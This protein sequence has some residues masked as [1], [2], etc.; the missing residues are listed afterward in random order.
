MKKLSRLFH[1]K[2]FNLPDWISFSRILLSPV[3]LALCFSNE[4]T[5]AAWLLL[6]GFTSDAV[7]GY[8]ARRKEMTSERGANLDS[9]GDALLF[10]VAVVGFV[11]FE[12]EFFM[13]HIL[14]IAAALVLYLLQ[15]VIALIKYGRT[16]S[17][18]TYLAKLSAVIQALFL[19]TG[20]FFYPIE[21]MFFIVIIIGIVETI[22]EIILIFRFKKWTANVKGLYWALGR[23]H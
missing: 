11:F 8:L 4:R 14:P 7:D 22:E 10:V 6:A 2:A 17:F 23:R 16:T 5:A 12:K 3:F 21:W 15:V 1:F 19:V 9:V 13:E 20:F 18:H